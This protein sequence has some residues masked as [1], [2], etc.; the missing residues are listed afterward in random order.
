MK[1]IKVL[2]RQCSLEFV[3]EEYKRSSA[4]KKGKRINVYKK[5]VQIREN[6]INLKFQ[7]KFDY[8]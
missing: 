7:V 6:Y 3:H 8:F 4:E 2:L 5:V 1:E